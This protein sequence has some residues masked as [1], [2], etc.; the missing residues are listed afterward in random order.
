MCAEWRAARAPR[1]YT[2]EEIKVMLLR[3]AG[4]KVRAIYAAKR[5]ATFKLVG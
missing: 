5:R 1:G 3:E 4:P 2:D